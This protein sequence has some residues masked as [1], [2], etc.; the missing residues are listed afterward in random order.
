MLVGRTAVGIG[1][2]G[3]TRELCAA[4]AA[5]LAEVFAFAALAVEAGLAWAE[6]AGWI[7]AGSQG[8]AW[9]AVGVWAGPEVA[10]EALA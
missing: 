4:W 8:R 6:P 1:V 10:I 9:V 3:G 7:L 2:A 5:Q